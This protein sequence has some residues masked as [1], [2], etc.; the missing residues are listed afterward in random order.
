MTGRRFRLDHVGIAVRSLDAAASTL[1]SLLGGQVEPPVE[2]P[3]QG[4]R[5]C[6]VRGA[7]GKLELLEP[8]DTG[9]SLARFLERHG[10]G[11]HHVC[12]AVPDIESEVARLEAEGAE[13]VD[14]VPRRGYRG[15]VA[16]V[17]PRA[18]HGVLIELWQPD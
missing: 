12:Y 18:A 8:A 1:A 14:P 6:F 16:F 11:L 17:H 5:L 10:E 13:L 15:R 3:D 2:L 4:V 7:Q 9:G